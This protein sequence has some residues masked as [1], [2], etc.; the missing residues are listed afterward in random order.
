MSAVE[1]S[2]VHNFT[3]RS[4]SHPRMEEIIRVLGIKEILRSTLPT[5]GKIPA[6][7]RV[8]DHIEGD[9]PATILIGAGDIR[10]I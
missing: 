9:I 3:L 5:V 2:K 1:N 10:S 8:A 6:P 7:S 4:R